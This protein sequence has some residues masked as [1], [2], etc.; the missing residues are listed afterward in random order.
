[1]EESRFVGKQENN[2][3]M[4]R[5]SFE[6]IKKIIYELAV[7]IN[8]PE[9]LLPTYG[10]SRDFAYPH[11]EIDNSGLLHYV[12]VERGQE[13]DHK[14]TDKLDDLLYWIFTSVT[15][16]MAC[17]Y[18]LKNRVEHRDGRRIIFEVQEELLGILNA[19]WREKQVKEN[20]QILARYP[21]DDYASLRATYCGILR[22][23]G[24]SEEEIN[25]L[26]YDKY[27]AK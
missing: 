18:E 26:A 25:Q 21:Y 14:V 4:T 6:S 5:F 23:K 13:L 15:S 19:N 20:S 8:A 11:I 7:K 10:Y 27:P 12:I 2:I 9:D 17:K 16:D 3:K 24:Y 1:M 22:E